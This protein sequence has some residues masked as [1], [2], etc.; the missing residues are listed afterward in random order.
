MENMKQT[1][2]ENLFLR[3]TKSLLEEE[4]VKLTDKMQAS[5]YSKQELH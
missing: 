1:F 2:L 3:I 4:K 5:D